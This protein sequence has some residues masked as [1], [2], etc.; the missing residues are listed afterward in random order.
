M[1]KA[2]E[3]IKSYIDDLVK[4]EE[5]NNYLPKKS[6]ALLDAVEEIE[7]YIDKLEADKLEAYKYIDDGDV[8]Y[9]MSCYEVKC[10]KCL[11][12]I[13]IEEHD[14]NCIVGKAEKYIKEVE[15]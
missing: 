12:L 13:D 4:E 14:E 5:H 15:K 11:R 2:L 6:L 10:S 7:S 9:E 3:I 1:N 8:S